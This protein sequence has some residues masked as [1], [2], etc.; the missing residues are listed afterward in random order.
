M[1]TS[2]R[3]WGSFVSRCRSIGSDPFASFTGRLRAKRP[4]SFTCAV[5]ML[6]SEIGR[7]Y[8][9]ITVTTSW[10]KWGSF[11][12]RCRPIGSDPFAFFTGR[13]RAK[14]P[15]RNCGWGCS[16]PSCYTSSSRRLKTW[17]PRVSRRKKAS[18]TLCLVHPR[19]KRG[20]GGARGSN[21][22][23]VS[24]GEAALGHALC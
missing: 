18:W 11:V 20:A 22:R 16:R 1:T 7:N 14:R 10:R 8:G 3:K 23:R 12:S 6:W 15:G 24:P 21:C 4:S 19:K 5:T 2:W 17:P 9:W 13:L